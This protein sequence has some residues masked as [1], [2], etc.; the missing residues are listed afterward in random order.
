MEEEKAKKNSLY[1]ILSIQDRTFK[2]LEELNFELKQIKVIDD[3]E[4]YLHY[5]TQTAQA[6]DE[7]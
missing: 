1:K 7:Y 2:T 6:N 3:K 4:T 5:L